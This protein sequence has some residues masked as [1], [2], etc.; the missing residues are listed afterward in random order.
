[1]EPAKRTSYFNELAVDL[2]DEAFF[3]SEIY[4]RTRENPNLNASYICH[5]CD[6]SLDEYASQLSIQILSALKT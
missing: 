6:D 3:S 1:M 4:G 5:P 2:N